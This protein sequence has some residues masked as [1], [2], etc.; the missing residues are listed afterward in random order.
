MNLQGPASEI[1]G[2]PEFKFCD[3]P[4]LI[5]S[6]DWVAYTQKGSQCGIYLETILTV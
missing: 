3:G 5:C 1:K 2:L 4:N 6:S